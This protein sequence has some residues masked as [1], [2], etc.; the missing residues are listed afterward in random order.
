MS[1]RTRGRK[2]VAVAG[3]A[4]LAAAL[5]AGLTA[6]SGAAGHQQSRLKIGGHA[7]LDRVFIIVLE[8]HSQR[9]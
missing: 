2:V 8:N 5:T 6:A 1:L 9:A 4:G 7:R 3:A